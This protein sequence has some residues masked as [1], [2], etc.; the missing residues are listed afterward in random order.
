M[1]LSSASCPFCLQQSCFGEVGS[2]EWGLSG[3]CVW[4][5]R[6]VTTSQPHSSSVSLSCSEKPLPSF[7]SLQPLH[8]DV[9]SGDA[10]AEG[11]SCSSSR[12]PGSQAGGMSWSAWTELV[13]SMCGSFEG[14]RIGTNSRIPEFLWLLILSRWRGEDLLCWCLVQE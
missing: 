1:H 6:A 4:E 9:R 11:P 7:P 13:W 5:R 3:L 14:R 12:S 10:A 8:G 2:W